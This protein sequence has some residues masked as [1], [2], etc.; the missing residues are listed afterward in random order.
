MAY[1]VAQARQWERLDKLSSHQARKMS[2]SR[3]NSSVKK[4]L[5]LGIWTSGNG[6]IEVGY[7]VPKGFLLSVWSLGV[8]KPLRDGTVGC[9]ELRCNGKGSFLLGGKTGTMATQ[10]D[11]FPK[12][13]PHCWVTT[14]M[15]LPFP[16]WSQPDKMREK[17]PSSLTFS[18]KYPLT[19]F[20][21]R[22]PQSK[23]KD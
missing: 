9:R 8:P 15:S 3:P 10:E 2:P 17:F 4:Q 13:G 11:V 12:E 23:K 7:V 14:D 6:E 5:D 1:L 19:R 16:C 20:L 18:R 22:P 21:M